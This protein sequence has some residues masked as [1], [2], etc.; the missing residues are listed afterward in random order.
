ME[1][2]WNEGAQDCMETYKGDDAVYNSQ[3]EDGEKHGWGISTTTSGE[4]RF[5]DCPI[6][7]SQR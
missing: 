3:W 1:G 2:I 4:R 5:E 6:E 7:E